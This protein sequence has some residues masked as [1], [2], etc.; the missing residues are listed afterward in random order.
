MLSYSYIRS[1]PTSPVLHTKAYSGKE[2]VLQGNY[3]N[4]Y[5]EQGALQPGA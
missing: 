5:L 1:N 4:L 2:I 3:Y